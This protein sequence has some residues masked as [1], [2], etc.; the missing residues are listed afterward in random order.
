MCHIRHIKHILTMS[1]VTHKW[2]MHMDI[3]DLKK[4]RIL[5]YAYNYC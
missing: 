3:S 1:Y 5:L 2:T 4:V